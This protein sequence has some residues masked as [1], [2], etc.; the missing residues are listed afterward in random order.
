MH[1]ITKNLILSLP[2]VR[3]S[4]TEIANSS[5]LGMIIFTLIS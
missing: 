5:M 4:M 1:I 3:G 2:E